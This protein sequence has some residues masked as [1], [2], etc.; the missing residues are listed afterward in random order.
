MAASAK[1]AQNYLTPLLL[2]VLVAA[3][4]AA[5]PDTRANLVLDLVP[6]TGSVLALKESLQSHHLPWMHLALSTAASIALAAVVVSW[7]ARLLDSERFCYPGL[8]RAGWGRFRRWGLGPLLP[9]GLEVMA[10]YAVAV[11]GMTYGGSL[12]SDASPPVVIV[13]PLLAFILLPPLIH[14]WL[15]AYP[16]RDLLQLHRPP[17]GAVAR[18][19]IAMP[20]AIMTSIAIGALQPEMPGDLNIGTQDLLDKL[21][22]YGLPVVLLCVAVIPALCEE[23]LCRGT[24]LSG[25]RQSIGDTGAVLVTAFLFATLH[26]SPYRFLPQ[27]TL[28][29]A[30][31][32]MTI[33][34]RS[35][36]PGMILHAG[37][38]AC[39]CLLAQYSASLEVLPGAA[40]VT[41][42]PPLALLGIGLMGLSFAI[43]M[44]RQQ[45]HQ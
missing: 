10:V 40:L 35:V 33:R 26:L 12:F 38:N 45:A 8:V 9:N 37:H 3:L 19:G 32:L 42:L 22:S 31:A 21:T 25:L 36:I 1:E 41:H 5:V 34:A 16:A 23:V 30:L 43:G 39:I 44:P 6:I 29:I 17:A 20:F 7:A 15:G 11:G 4:V 2:V 14:C 28:G 13:G 24:L 27:F 18:A